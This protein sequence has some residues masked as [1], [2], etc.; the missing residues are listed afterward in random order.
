MGDDAIRTKFLVMLCFFK[1]LFWFPSCS[2]SSPFGHGRFCIP[3]S[4]QA[5]FLVWNTTYIC[6]HTRSY[7]GYYSPLNPPPICINQLLLISIILLLLYLFFAV[8]NWLLSHPLAPF[9]TCILADMCITGLWLCLHD[10]T[11]KAIK[12]QKTVLCF[13]SFSLPLPSGLYLMSFRVSLFF[14]SSSTIYIFIIWFLFLFSFLTTMWHDV[15]ARLFACTP[16]D[17]HTRWVCTC[18]YS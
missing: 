18:W 11:S 7:Q 6:S 12:Q 14:S 3:F 17:V 4:F 9:S 16:Y 1:S 8:Q 13:P 10:Q 2:S 15:E 5:H